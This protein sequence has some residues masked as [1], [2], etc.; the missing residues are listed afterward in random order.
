MTPSCISLVVGLGASMVIYMLTF[1]WFVKRHLEHERVI[2]EL[3]QKLAH[4]Y[5][6]ESRLRKNIVDLLLT[7]QGLETSLRE[8]HEVIRNWK[9]SNGNT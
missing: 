6:E 8:A 3:R 7:Q 1:I 2:A 9:E 4:S 5:Q